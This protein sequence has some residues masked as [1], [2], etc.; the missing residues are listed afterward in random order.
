MRQPILH[1]AMGH[2]RGKLC[3]G[4]LGGLCALLNR[5]LHT[6]RMKSARSLRFSA[7]SGGVADRI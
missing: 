4:R 5:E 1:H 7:S 2:D 3:D 6:K